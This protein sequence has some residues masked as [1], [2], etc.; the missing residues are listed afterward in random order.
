MMLYMEITVPSGGAKKFSRDRHIMFKVSEGCS[1]IRP[2]QC[3]SNHSHTTNRKNLARS[4][5][6]HCAW[7]SIIFHIDFIDFTERLKISCFRPHFGSKKFSLSRLQ[8]SVENFL[9]VVWSCYRYVKV[10]SG[11]KLSNA[12]TLV[13]IRRLQ[14]S[15]N[16]LVLKVKSTTK[17]RP[18]LN[19]MFNRDIL[20]KRKNIYF[21]FW[22]Y[23]Y[24]FQNFQ[25]PWKDP[26]SIWKKWLE[27]GLFNEM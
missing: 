17:K 7:F 26:P 19:Y 6:Q 16:V 12:L 15:L 4:G 27:G 10:F 22:N 2:T 25:K 21:E 8:E 11:N 18:P 23:V 14:R 3:T 13:I 9:L 24:G 20:K 1:V 5:V